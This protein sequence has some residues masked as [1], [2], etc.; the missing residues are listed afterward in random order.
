MKF[1]IN[2]YL[3]GLDEL[4]KVLSE[5]E[6]IKNKGDL[7]MATVDDLVLVVDQV[8]DQVGRLGPAVDALEA[9]L[10]QALKNQGISPEAQA[11]IDAAVGR[12]Q[13]VVANVATAIADATDGVDEANVPPP[14]PEPVV[15]PAVEPAPNA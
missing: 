1:N 3:H 9:Q 2:V 13:G 11:K 4:E 10:T 5:L 14:A 6:E 12:L 7:I 15:T 8:L